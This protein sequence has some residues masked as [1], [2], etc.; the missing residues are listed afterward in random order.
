LVWSTTS[1]PTTS[2]YLG[3]TYDGFADNSPW[4]SNITSLTAS[5][6]YHVRAYATNNVGTSYGADVSFTTASSSTAPSITTTTPTSI[7]QTTATGGGEIVS[8]GGASVTA[9]GVVWSTSINPTTALST[10]T[11]DGTGTGVFSSSVTSLTAN[12][13]YHIRAYATNS[14]GTSY[15]ADTTFTTLIIPTVTTPTSASVATTT[16]T[17]GANVTSLGNPASIS[18]RGVCYGTSASP[19]TPCSTASGTTT[20]IYT[21]NITGLT[22]GTLYYYRGFATNTTGTAYSADGTFTTTAVSTSVTASPT[23]YSTTPSTNISFTYTPTTNTGSTECRLLDN[24]SA[25]LTSYQASSPIVYASASTSGSFGYYVECRNS[26]Y[27]TSTGTSALITVTVAAAVSSLVGTP[28]QYNSNGTVSASVAMPTGVTTSDIMFAHILHYYGTADVLNS[29]PSGWY[30]AGGTGR[31]RNGVYNQALY[32]KVATAGETGP[33]VFGFSGTAK[34]A[35]TISAYRGNFNSAN[36]IDAFSNTEY[37]TSNTSYQAAS[38]TVANANSTVLMFPSVYNTTI[39]TFTEPTTQSG[40]WTEDY[41]HGNTAPDFSRAA[42]RKLI[43]ASGATGVITSVGSL[44]GTT[45][46]HAFAV[47]LNSNMTAVPTLTTTSA[48]GATETTASSGGNI[49]SQGGAS[50]TARGVVWSTSSGPTT[51]LATKTSDGT[52]TG[53]F[54]S[55]I[56]GLTGGTTYYVRAYATNTG[57]TAYGNEITFATSAPACGGHAF[58]NNY[59]WYR[60]TTVGQTCGTFCTG[61]GKT[62]VDSTQTCAQDNAAL[63]AAGVTC[64]TTDLNSGYNTTA[65]GFQTGTNA[66]NPRTNTAWSCGT[67]AVTTSSCSSSRAYWN[68][69]CSCSS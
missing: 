12:T 63:A 5:T 21:T 31:H 4:T 51:A 66:C 18:A 43:T 22:P 3:I 47:V 29:I 35:V 59:C 53:S 28:T 10:K 36:P 20:G 61:I 27:T 54:S 13:L 68:M 52:G 65:P 50:V 8:D 26:T 38:L 23:T 30:P 1:N 34:V 42:Y 24:V 55:S 40:G 41:D 60:Q 14:V 67:G 17:L 6:L 62:C 37:V 46:K 64:S 9:R 25:A 58:Y 45:I 69:L 11:S 44:S 16:V 2:S 39:R 56:T 48:S 15:G 57:G 33:Y 19:T 49:S 7:A 32:Y